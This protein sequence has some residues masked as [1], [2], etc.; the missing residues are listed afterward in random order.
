MCDLLGYTEQEILS[1]PYISFV[2]PD[3]NSI[4][5]NSIERMWRSKYETRGSYGESYQDAIECFEIAQSLE[6][7]ASSLHNVGLIYYET[8]QY[9][10]AALAF[11]QA[12][13]I[14]GE[15]AARHIALAKVQEKL[16][17]TKAMIAALERA[18]ELEP[19]PQSLSILA[20]AYERDEQVELATTLREKVAKVII[21]S[22]ALQKIHQPRKI[23]M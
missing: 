4:H 23:V 8:G 14:E 19:N 17:N 2:H 6:P 1:K 13:S 22:R 16:G 3:D 11:E 20:D 5:T 10:K 18:V 7:S 12:I 21:P 9:E 15:L